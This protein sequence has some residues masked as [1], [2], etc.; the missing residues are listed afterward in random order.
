MRSARCSCGTPL[1]ESEHKAVAF[2]VYQSVSGSHLARVA[3]MNAVSI[4]FIVSGVV[5]TMLSL[6]TDRSARDLRRLARSLWGLRRSPWLTGSVLRH[7]RDYDRRGVHPDDH[8]SSALIEEWRT[9]LF[10]PT[11]SLADRRGTTRP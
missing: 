5:A 2:D 11:G 4:G 8:D 10:G 3:V 7:L 9:R 6:L 1:E